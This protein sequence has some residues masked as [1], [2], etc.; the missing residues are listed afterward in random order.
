MSFTE[1][2]KFVKSLLLFCKIYALTFMFSQFF[3][4]VRVLL[5]N[6]NSFVDGMIGYVES[7]AHDCTMR[8]NLHLL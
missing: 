8:V 3:V 7:K 4:D 2:I 1:F 6:D 5:N